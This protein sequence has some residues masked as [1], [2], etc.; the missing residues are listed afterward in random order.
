MKA[1]EDLSLK[2]SL[3]NIHKHIEASNE[4]IKSAEN[5]DFKKSNFVEKL[6]TA[7]KVNEVIDELKNSNEKLN[8]DTKALTKLVITQKAEIDSYRNMPLAKQIKRK[9][10]EMDQLNSS[11]DELEKKIDDY[12]FDI[13]MLNQ[14]NESSNKKIEKLEI[15]LDLHKSFVS[16]LGLDMLFKKFKNR[17]LHN[18]EFH[19]SD[20]IDMCV[21][22]I[23]SIS[24][25]KDTL[26]ERIR[27]LKDKNVDEDIVYRGNNTNS[28]TRGER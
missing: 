11:I 16:F 20:V 12:K 23:K 8:S 18:R 27:F 4:I 25:M 17:F 9:D 10:I 5:I 14:K 21:D 22:A 3:S 13:K 24:D 1:G 15:E 2:E 26:I 19:L 28:Y 6:K 7:S